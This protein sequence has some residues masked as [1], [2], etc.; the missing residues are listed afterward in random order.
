MLS[1]KMLRQGLSAVARQNSVATPLAAVANNLSNTGCMQYHSHTANMSNAASSD[2][3]LESVGLDYGS[4]D[5]YFEKARLPPGEQTNKRAFTYFVLGSAK[6]MWASAVRLAV[7]RTVATMSASADVLALAS[8]EV[9]LSGVDEGACL[10]VKWRGKPVFIKRRS[11]SQIKEVRE[12]PVKY[13]RDPQTDEERVQDPQ[14]LIVLGI[15][16]HLGCVPIPNAGNYKGW[17]C[18]CHGSHYDGAGRIRQGPAPLNLEIPP[19]KFTEGGN[20]VVIG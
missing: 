17:F 4:V 14:W 18:P 8:L 11:E 6:F 5:N 7:V 3:A 9:D 16:T 12:E 19:Y 13:L 1:T 2:K 10:T 15:C 20:K